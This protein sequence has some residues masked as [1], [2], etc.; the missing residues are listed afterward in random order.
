MEKYDICVIGGGPSGYAAAM[1][2]I[3]FGKKTILIERGKIGGAS[4]YNGALTSKTTWEVSSRIASINEMLEQSDRPFFEIPWQDVRQTVSE[5]VFDR[6]QQYSAHLK[7]LKEE[8]SSVRF[9]HAR[10]AGKFLSKNEIQITSKKGE[11]VI[12]AENTIVATGSRPRK[13]PHIETDEQLIMTSDGIDYIEDYPKSLVILGAGVIGCEYA[14]IISNFGKTKVYLID[15]ADRILPFEDED[16]AGM[17]SQNLRANGV[18]IHKLAKLERM[19]VVDGEVE[20][21]ISNPD[22]TSEVIRVEKA[23]L[24]V[25]RIPN[26]EELGLENAGVDISDRNHILDTNTQ[27][28]I[29]NIYAV[30]DV[31]GHIALVNV[32]EIEG[33][34]AVEK[35]VGEEVGD[36][37]YDNV[38]TIMFLHPEVAAVG[39]NE[40]QCI[41]Q[42]KSIKV[43]KL[44]FSC[45]ARA[46]AMRK[47]QGFFKIIVTD[48]EDMRILGMRAIGEHASSAI[49]AIGLLIKMDHPI[50][51]LADLVHPH[52]SIIEGI[53]ECVRMLLN[54]S[55]FKSAVFKDAMQC[56]R[57]QAGKVEHLQEL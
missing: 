4:I 36:M 28:S 27:T 34:Y 13:L 14:T 57:R 12:W 54:K 19:E 52:P 5:A 35:I 11:E 24:S 29:P 48:D 18:T 49:Q 56:Y 45:I 26:T 55:I 8:T 47:T 31:T 30:G 39:M 25:G 2:A 37:T 46:I 9:R 6:K 43:V 15:R 44:D 53:Q 33:R 41:E 50:E 7:L 10:G 51:V 21:E 16:I 40:L 23:L 32:G 17:V 3:D 22:G 1:R 38:C 42:G 20:Y